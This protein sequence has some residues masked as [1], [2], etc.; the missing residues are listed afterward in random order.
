M[1]NFNNFF[2]NDLQNEITNEELARLAN[3]NTFNILMGNITMK[4]LFDQDIDIP[5]LVDPSQG[6]LSDSAKAEVLDGMIEYYVE[7][8]EYEKCS[9]LVELKNKL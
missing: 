2:N 6:S 5:L 1:E 3:E 4:E 9:K 7:Q 8:E